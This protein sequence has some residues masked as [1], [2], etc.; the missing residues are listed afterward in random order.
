MRIS[1]GEFRS[2]CQAVGGINTMINEDC[3]DKDSL[4]L[5]KYISLVA[6]HVTKMV[7]KFPV[8]LVRNKQWRIGK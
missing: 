6:C 3:K 4:A 1:K 8:S 2:V 5:V 7:P